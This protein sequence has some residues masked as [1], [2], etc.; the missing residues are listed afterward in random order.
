MVSV[1]R[2]F[3]TSSESDRS[4]TV[5]SGA[6]SIDLAYIRNRRV[7]TAWKV[8]PQTRPRRTDGE[9]TFDGAGR[10]PA[11]SA[12]SARRI[13]SAAA[14]R[15][16]VSSRI[17]AGSAPWATSQATRWA[18]V[19]VFPVPAPAMMSR[20]DSPCVTASRWRGLRPLNESVAAAEW[21]EGQG[22]GADSPAE[23]GS[24]GSVVTGFLPLV[25]SRGMGR[26]VAGVVSVQFLQFGYFSGEGRGWQVRPT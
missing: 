11:V 25:G 21:L 9:E 13:I 6:I 20:G 24:T 1:R 4:R 15:V 5:K 23:S 8:P 18:S 3:I 16:N 2:T 12:V 17:L 19:V 22:G 14:R 10:L 26:S 7:A